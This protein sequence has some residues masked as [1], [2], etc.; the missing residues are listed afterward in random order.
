MKKSIILFILI[1]IVMTGCNCESSADNLT[2]IPTVTDTITATPI[3]VV[4]KEEIDPMVE[5]LVSS[6]DSIGEVELDDEATIEKLITQYNS[7][8]ENKKNQ[9]RNHNLLIE[10]EKTLEQIKKENLEKYCEE[11]KGKWKQKNSDSDSTYMVGVIDDNTIKIFSA[12]NDGKILTLYWNG[13]YDEPTEVLESYSWVSQKDTVGSQY[14]PRSSIDETKEFSFVDGTLVCE[15]KQSGT[16]FKI[17]FEHA[18]IDLNGYNEDNID[19]NNEVEHFWGIDITPTKV[20]G[21]GSQG[22]ESMMYYAPKAILQIR[23][24]NVDFSKEEYEEQFEDV[25]EWYT[26]DTK[27]S[28]TYKVFSEEDYIIDGQKTK[29]LGYSAE[30]YGCKYVKYYSTIFYDSSNN[31]II[32]IAITCGYETEYDY[33][34]DFKQILESISQQ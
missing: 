11:I 32:S 21:F 14:W 12:Y 7:L 29:I 18:D 15:G 20:Y 30:M 5:N 33:Y 34:T 3:P 9:V 28:E 23:A 13:S 17:E 6:I 4:E 24:M 10:A 16:T 31:S 26:Y 8:D 25:W 22:Y 2:N 1:G 27:T 19:N